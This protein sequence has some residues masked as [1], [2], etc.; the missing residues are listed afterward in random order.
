DGTV[1][2]KDCP[3]GLRAFYKRTARFAGATL[4][5]MLAL[6]SIGFG[7]SKSKKE[8]ACKNTS[9]G[10]ILRTETRNVN[11]VNG[12]IADPNCAAVPGAK[13]TLIS[14]KTKR[15]YKAVSNEKGYYSVLLVAP[16]RY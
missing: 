4:T 6:F 8:D 2:T 9:P 3:V 1:I 14:E 13:I 7:Q 5:A 16:G 10:K 15:E 12:T 11:L